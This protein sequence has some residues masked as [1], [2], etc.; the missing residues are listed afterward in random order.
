MSA[1]HLLPIR[2]VLIAGRLEQRDKHE[3]DERLTVN[4]HVTVDGKVQQMTANWPIS[5][6]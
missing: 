3:N 6:L 2:A 1:E 5:A 4:G